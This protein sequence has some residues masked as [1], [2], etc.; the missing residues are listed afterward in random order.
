MDTFELITLTSAH[1]CWPRHL[2]DRLD[3]AAP[4][5]LWALGNHEILARPKVGLFCSVHCPAHVLQSAAGVVHGLRDRDLAVASG[6]HSP[7]EKACL[8]VLLNDHVPALI[9]FARS[10]RKI[11]IPSVWQGPLKEGRLLAI[12]PFDD[13]P[14][15]P[16]RKSSRQRNELIA[17]MADEVLILYAEPGGNVARL[18]S[19]IDRWRIPRR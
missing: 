9:G 14:R 12:S 19:M 15:S 2:R 7:V 5:K 1:P 16:T 3:A 18:A 6:F 8:Q 11:R 4:A 17:A 13:L 10:L